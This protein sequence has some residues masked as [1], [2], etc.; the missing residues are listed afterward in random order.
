MPTRR[1]I[2]RAFQ[3]RRPLATHIAQVERSERAFRVVRA[4]ALV[5]LV[6]LIQRRSIKL[7][8]RSSSG[9]VPGGSAPTQDWQ[10]QFN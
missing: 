3:L 6:L 7:S 1:P 2:S 10:G 8:M 9:G 5:V 4:G